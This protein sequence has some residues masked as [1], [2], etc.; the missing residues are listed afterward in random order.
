MTSGEQGIPAGLRERVF[1][2]FRP[3]RPLAR[4]WKR[5]L[6][7]APLAVALLLLVHVRYGTRADLGV[8]FVWGLSALQ[9][10]VGIG[11]VMAALR[12]VIPDRSLSP[13]A[14]FALFAGGFALAIAITYAAWWASGSIAPAAVR[15][16]FWKICFRGT[17][18]VGLPA[19]LLILLL[20]AKGVMWRPSLVGGLAGL[21]SGLIADASWRTF[22]EVAEPAHVFS[23]HFAGIVVLT[24]LGVLLGHVAA[25]LSSP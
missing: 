21:S 23:A 3:V 18:Q 20:A 24:L 14:R 17:I 13:R 11:L 9:V 4:P 16:R 25:R 8:L 22:C 1:A 7:L 19:L 2:D 6:A 5:A 12:E 10:A 15:Y